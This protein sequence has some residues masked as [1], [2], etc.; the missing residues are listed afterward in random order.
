M[1]GASAGKLWLLC[2]LQEGYFCTLASRYNSVS[3]ASLRSTLIR[4]YGKAG[5]G[6]WKRTRK[7]ETDVENGKSYTCAK[8]NQHHATWAEG[9]FSIGPQS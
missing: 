7:A 8:R 2:L 4:A 5:N 9:N 6:K 1:F 3:A